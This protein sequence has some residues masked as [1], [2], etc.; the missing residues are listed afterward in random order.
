[1]PDVYLYQSPDDG[2]IN[3][4]NGS[5][6]LQE[7]P[8]SAAYISLFGGNVN[9]SAWWGDADMVSAT[10]E[11]IDK[12]APT[13]GNLRKLEEAVKSDLAWMTQSPYGWAVDA[14]ASMESVN[15]VNIVVTINGTVYQYSQ[16]WTK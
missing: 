13:S 10:Q 16:E 14:S 8:S 15:R 9:G 3:I 2:E 11:F 1:M 4:E 5:V 6:E 7:S 12:Y